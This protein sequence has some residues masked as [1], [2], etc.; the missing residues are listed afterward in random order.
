[1]SFNDLQAFLKYRAAQQAQKRFAAGN[2]AGSCCHLE[3]KKHS[4][5]FS[6]VV[7]VN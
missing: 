7:R 5:A 2:V 4:A 1:M 6:Y 3:G